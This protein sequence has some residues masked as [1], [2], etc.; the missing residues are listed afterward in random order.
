MTCDDQDNDQVCDV[1]DNCPQPWGFNP[2]QMDTDNDGV[3]DYC[4]NC[5]DVSNPDQAD[6]N[7]DF[8]GDF[9][10]DWDNDTILDDVD[11][12][13]EDYNDTQSNQDADEFGDACDNCN[14]VA[15][16][17]QMDVNDDGEGDACDVDSDSDGD[18]LVDATEYV[19]GT[20]PT[21]FDTDVDGID[22]DLDASPL[23]PDNG[24]PVM[25]GDY[26]TGQFM[27]DELDQGGSMLTHRMLLSMDGTVRGLYQ[28]LSSST[29]GGNESG[30]WYYDPAYDSSFSVIYEN[31]LG[32]LSES[33]NALI[34]SNTDTA[35]NAISLMVGGKLS[36]GMGLSSLVGNY[37]WGEFVNISGGAYP[38]DPST[39][40]MSLN[41]NDQTGLVHYSSIDDSRG[42]TDEGDA[43][44]AV[45]DDGSLVMGPGEGFV[46]PDGELLMSIDTADDPDIS[47]GL[48]VRQG[49]GMSTAS[50]NG[51]FFFARIAGHFV[52]QAS[53]FTSTTHM[54]LTFD[55][56]GTMTYEKVGDSLGESE[57]G[58]FPYSVASDGA[59]TIDGEPFGTVSSN[60]EYLLVVDADKLPDDAIEFG[61]GI[62]K[63]VASFDSDGDTLANLDELLVGSDP[64][65]PD[66][67]GDGA[68][69][70]FD[71]NPVAVNANFSWGGI[72]NLTPGTGEA[73]AYFDVGIKSANT[74]SL[75]GLTVSI[76]GPNGYSY[77]FTDG[78][79]YPWK[80]GILGMGHAEPSIDPG[81]Y[82]LT[83]TD[84]DGNSVHQVDIHDSVQVT[85]QVDLTTVNY[86]RF[87]D[88]N[89]RFM[90]A[91]VNDTRTY[92]YRFR[93][94]DMAGNVV[95]N[96]PREAK[97]VVDVPSGLLVDDTS[98]KYRIEV[99]ET[100][101]FDTL[102]GKSNTDKV[103]FVPTATDYNP[104]LPLVN[105]AHGVNFKLTNETWRSYFEIGFNDG[106]EVT[107]AE[108]LGPPGFTP[109]TFS[110][111]ELGGNSIKVS[112]DPTSYT[113][114]DGQYTFHYVANGVD[115][116]RYAT[117]TPQVSYMKPDASTFQAEFLGDGMTVRFTFAPIE[118]LVPMSYRV[119][120][121]NQSGGYFQTSRLDTTVID[122][123]YHEIESKI[124]PE[125]WT[126]HVQPYDSSEWTTTRN[127]STGDNVAFAPSTFN[128]DAPQVN[129]AFVEHRIMP[130]SPT[131]ASKTVLKFEAYDSDLAELKVDFP[132]GTTSYD[133]L[134][135]GTLQTG[136]PMGGYWYMLK[137]DGAPQT[138]LYTF[139]ATDAAANQTVR[140]DYQSVPDTS[141]TP[142][143]FTTL[144]IDELPD[145]MYRA[146]GSP[147]HSDRPLYYAPEML[148]LADYNGDGKPDSLGYN[149][150]EAKSSHTFDPA[151]LPQ[152]PL[153]VRINGRD[154]QHWSIFNN[155][156]N[157][158]YVGYEGAGFDY[159]SLTDSDFDGW[160]SNVD[161]DDSDPAL[162][163]AGGDSDQD[164]VTDGLDNC[165]FDV[166]PG[167]EDSDQNGIGDACDVIP[168]A[169]ITP[170]GGESFDVGSTY[171]VEW[172]ADPNAV[173]Y[174]LHYFDAD[175]T[176]HVVANVGN[177]T[178]YEWQIPLDAVP[179]SGK[180]FRVTAFDAADAKLGEAWSNGTFT[181]VL[182]PL[183][184]LSPANGET[185]TVDSTYTLQ[186]TPHPDA[187]RYRLHYFD[188]DSTPHVV[189][190]VGAVS[191][192]LWNVPEWVTPESGKTFRIT[193]F[194]GA[195]AKLGESWLEGTFNVVPNP[196]VMT[197]PSPGVTWN[198]GVEYTITW[199]AHP[200]ATRY[201]IH[202]FDA[203]DT[204]HKV[205]KFVTG[206]SVNWTVP[207]GTTVED[208]KKL[209]VTAFNA[210]NA[211]LG[212]AWLQGTFNVGP[213]FA[214]TAPS[215]GEV[216]ALNSTQTIQWNA[217]PLAV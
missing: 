176:P 24:D 18:T 32:Q 114:P 127:R 10:Q 88:G 145:G 189:A 14:L 160:A 199:G 21:R 12:C 204:P 155:R 163:Y 97:V 128:S 2:D 167:Q 59:V 149:P 5:Y 29:G 74:T 105:Y 67:D 129:M 95:H 35:D 193:A 61:L 101:G 157:S 51:E 91:P 156:F 175:N 153:I 103:T 172:N 180:L 69:D 19:M 79:I 188:V 15:N 195:D 152:V 215:G 85:P 121:N 203:D 169:M 146:S 116:Y 107:A 94:Y 208:G 183:V 83:V 185:W 82:T 106:S 205:A 3:G 143:D 58:L 123:P 194:D 9:C 201:N 206:T 71:S 150:Y 72:Q 133:L 136:S 64:Y 34:I 117:L 207:Y 89:Y 144:H 53:P 126:W 186:W 190:N 165:P 173:R 151:T 216:W 38:L 87:A 37:I 170:N 196:Y 57:N 187:V 197:E 214:M 4:D 70:G 213:A 96:T 147:L 142:V 80:P 49:A 104:L 81:H 13:V 33:G 109:Y 76:S 66:T 134:L 52:D 100:S 39:K 6:W 178:S 166:N 62:K 135:D 210:V 27:D 198:L 20:D 148:F 46:T 162:N 108:L 78:D 84:L 209:R 182:Q 98:Y 115:Q 122:V 164:G 54:I 55:G 77:T 137:L 93:I 68:I 141:Y 179:E 44:Y 17:D 119:R 75:T 110:A 159:S 102:E 192:L 25:T 118:Q 42:D 168:F 113:T 124:G 191:S 174:R 112:L 120:V 200:E 1:V 125:P 90:W 11:N 30:H 132:D 140:Y 31:D 171:S 22:D 177:V 86:Q 139:T 73:Q 184:V 60:G 63:G 56:I 111:G 212:E 47:L 131:P 36:S 161:I 7:Q 48:A 138:G 50:L 41:F 154:A 45:A 26:L 211:K 23:V 158:A 202:Y 16:P 181:V 40:L 217:H 43:P 92:Y 130:G 65:I 8:I 99:H 28:G